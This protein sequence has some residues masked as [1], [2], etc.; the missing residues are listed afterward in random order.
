MYEK[1]KEKPPKNSYTV[2]V[3]RQRYLF[4][5]FVFDVSDTYIISFERIIT[6][7]VNVF[8]DM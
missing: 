5:V 8:T 6:Q 1:K 3:L 2:T 7:I 4:G